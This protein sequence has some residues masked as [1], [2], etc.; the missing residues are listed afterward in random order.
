MASSLSNFLKNL[1]EDFHK[2]KCKYEHGYKKCETCKNKY[3]DCGC[4]LKYANVKINLIEY[5]FP[6]IIKKPFMNILKKD[7]LIHVN[8]Q[9]M[10]SINLFHCCGIIGESSMKSHC[11]KKKILE[12]T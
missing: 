12:V 3:K 8:L 2:I 11:L 10:T 7:L 4:C 1:A 9:T 6:R 5:K